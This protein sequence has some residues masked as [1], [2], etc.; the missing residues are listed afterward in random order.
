M[1]WI[2]PILYTLGTTDES[3]GGT[4]EGREPMGLLWSMRPAP[5]SPQGL[6][7]IRLEQYNSVCFVLPSLNSGF[8]FI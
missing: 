2:F 6:R 1:M 3:L 7:L 8:F 5:G 4:Y